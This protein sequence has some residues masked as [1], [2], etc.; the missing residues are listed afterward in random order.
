MP[1]KIISQFQKQY[2]AK[3]GKQV[4]YATANKQGRDKET[5]KKKSKPSRGDGL[6]KA[7]GHL[8]AK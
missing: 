1:Q 5:F 3:K 4:F 8:Q 2:G 6:S 7:M